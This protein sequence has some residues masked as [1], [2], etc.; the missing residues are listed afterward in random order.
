MQNCLPLATIIFRIQ[1]ED[2]VDLLYVGTDEDLRGCGLM[3]VAMLALQLE[4][5]KV[6]VQIFRERTDQTTT[7]LNFVSAVQE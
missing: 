4:L 2:L 6:C 5:A 7:L 1:G 3:Q